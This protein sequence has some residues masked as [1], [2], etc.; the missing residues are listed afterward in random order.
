MDSGTESGLTLPLLTGPRSTDPEALGRAQAPAFQ[1]APLP[2]AAHACSCSGAP[3]LKDAHI[4]LLMDG[5]F[6]SVPVAEPLK[7]LLN[8][9]TIKA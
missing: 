9:G 3:A 1:Q 2:G 5:V 8:E 4:L 6:S 7:C